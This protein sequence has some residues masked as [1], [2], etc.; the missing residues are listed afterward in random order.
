MAKPGDNPKLE[1]MNMG[2]PAKS[3]T[4]GPVECLGMTFPSDAERREYFLGKLAEKLKDPEFRKIEGFRIGEDEDILAL[5]DPPYYTACPNP[6]LTDFIEHY[7]TPYNAKQKYNR[8]PFSTDV[9]ENKHHPIYVAHT[10]HTKVPHRAI[11]RYILHYTEPGDLVFDGFAGTGMTGVAAQLC[12]NREEVSALG[13]SV[14]SDGTI[15]DEQGKPFSKIGTRRAILNDLSPAATFITNNYNNDLHF[16]C[17]GEQSSQII[18]SL[19]ARF[20][21]MYRTLHLPRQKMLNDALTFIKDND[22]KDLS[23]QMAAL[24][25]QKELRHEEMILLASRI[26]TTSTHRGIYMFYPAHGQPFHLNIDG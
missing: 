4:S 20:G 17:Y 22:S 1:Q 7:G 12:G 5:S 11:M 13:Y 3:A 16:E 18:N 24:D 15:L 6:W 2:L 23:S 14:K 9:K 21:W 19:E 25:F 26:S 10:Y 8:E